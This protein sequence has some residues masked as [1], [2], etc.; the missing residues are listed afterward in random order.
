MCVPSMSVWVSITGLSSF[1]ITLIH[2][3][4][5]FIIDPLFLRLILPRFPHVVSPTLWLSSDKAFVNSYRPMGSGWLLTVYDAV[6]LWVS[7]GHPMNMYGTIIGEV[8]FTP[9]TI[10]LARLMIISWLHCC[11]E[12]VRCVTLGQSLDY[13]LLGFLL[14]VSVSGYFTVWLAILVAGYISVCLAI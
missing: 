5:L 10:W 7:S 9:E 6:L 13:V 4:S 2:I 3:I 12:S 8:R 14:L 11:R 1:S